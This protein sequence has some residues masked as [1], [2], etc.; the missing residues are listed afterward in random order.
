MSDFTLPPGCEV[1]ELER[2]LEQDD[3]IAVLYSEENAAAL[4]ALCAKL[5]EYDGMLKEAWEEL[6]DDGSGY[7]DVDREMWIDCLRRRVQEAKP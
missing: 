6:P 4:A 7:T 5:R 3:Q 1:P 2:I